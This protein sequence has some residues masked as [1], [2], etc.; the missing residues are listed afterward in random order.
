M[1]L[2]L[3][4]YSIISKKF[5]TTISTFILLLLAMFLL[6]SSSSHT[7]QTMAIRDH[8][9]SLELAGHFDHFDD[10]TGKLTLADILDSKNTIAFTPSNNTNAS[11]LD[12]WLVREMIQRQNGSVTL[13]KNDYHVMATVR[14][15]LA[16]NV[17]KR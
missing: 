7:A 4:M 5:F 11:G 17:E 9:P 14:I 12:L 15:P 1:N 13:E 10:P 6:F 3:L 2:A 16:D 8:E